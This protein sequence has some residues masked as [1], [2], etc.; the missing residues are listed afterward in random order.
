VS[1]AGSVPALRAAAAGVA[2]LAALL[3]GACGRVEKDRP[4]DEVIAAAKAGD[5][6]AVRDL[7]HR[8]AHPDPAVFQKA[9]DAVTALG[10]AAEPELIAALSDRNP[11]VA[12][13]SASKAAVEPLIGALKTWDSRRY[14]AAWALG[15]IQDTRA[16]PTLVAAMGDQ[17][18][19]T[20]KYATRSLIKFSTQATPALVKALEDP[21]A[22]VRH[23]AV[24]ALGEIRDPSSYDA[25]IAMAGKVDREVHLWALGRIADRRGFPIVAAAVSDAD[26]DV[27][28][29]AIQALKDLGDERAIP[30]LRATLED[31]EWMIREWSARGLESITSHRQTYRNQHGEQVYPYSLYR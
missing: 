25:V 1:Q 2:L 9:L 6:A 27:R 7:V 20:A 29:A 30:L 8:F 10:P 16:I 28:L 12:E 21:S 19:E 18:V 11:T 13:T 14:V 24:R 17:D 22:Q 3:A 15:E 5:Q 4:L 23:Y 26:R 31:P